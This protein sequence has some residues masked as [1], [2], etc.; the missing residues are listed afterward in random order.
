MPHLLLCCV[1]IFINSKDLFE[2][3]PA[4]CCFISIYKWI[5]Q[6]PLY[7]HTWFHSTIAEKNILYTSVLLHLLALLLW[8]N[9]QLSLENTP[10]TPQKKIIFQR[11]GA[12][13][14]SVSCDHWRCCS[15]PLF[16]ST[17]KM[18]C[19]SLL[20]AWLNSLFASPTLLVDYVCNWHVF[21]MDWAFTCRMSVSQEPFLWGF[22][23]L[24]ACWGVWFIF[25][26]LSTH[27]FLNLNLR[28]L[29]PYSIKLVP[30]VSSFLLL[31]PPH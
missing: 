8:T 18:G 16:L 13:L 1:F 2:P 15:R 22:I 20:L 30:T 28:C 3:P 25:L 12:P 5:S 19:W 11:C 17:L 6:N 29:F 24:T 23:F 21:L 27:S 14:S 4:I 9:P 10:H 26:I 7:C 31:L